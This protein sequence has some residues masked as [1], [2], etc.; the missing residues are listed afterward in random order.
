MLKDRLD[1]TGKAGTVILMNPYGLHRGV[2]PKSADRLMLGYSFSLHPTYLSPE[3][4]VVNLGP[5]QGCDPYVNRRFVSFSED[6]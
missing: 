6:G 3:R 5:I 4:P 2:V 1:I